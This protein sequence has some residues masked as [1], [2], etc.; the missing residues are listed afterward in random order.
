MHRSYSELIQLPSFEERFRYLSL[1][2]Q[3]GRETFGF[4]RYLNQKFYTSREWRNLRHKIIV[5]D[6]GC[7]MGVDGFEIHES[8][9]IHHLNP[10]TVADVESSDP[11]ILD[12]DNLISVT[13]RTHNAIHYGDE[14]LPP[15]MLIE[16]KPG[17]T[18]LW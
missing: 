1:R 7:D 14:R 13:H 16:R 4:D 9:Y 8:I 6:N 10:M 18:K 17:D 2:G 5:R 3:V 11:R 12:P 15:R